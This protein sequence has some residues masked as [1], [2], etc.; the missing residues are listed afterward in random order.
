MILIIIIIIIII[1]NIDISIDNGIMCIINIV[2][3]TIN[4]PEM[5]AE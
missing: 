2:D 4:W 5:W 1:V 3:I